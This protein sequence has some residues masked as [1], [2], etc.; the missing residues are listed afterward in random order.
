MTPLP[1]CNQGQ[2]LWSSLEEQQPVGQTPRVY[3]LH[4]LGKTRL[5][6]SWEIRFAGRASFTILLANWTCS[7]SP[8]WGVWAVA[9][10][11]KVQAQEFRWKQFC[12]KQFSG[13]ASDLYFHS[14][15]S[16][17]SFWG[18]G[19]RIHPIEKNWDEKLVGHSHFCSVLNVTP[20]YCCTLSP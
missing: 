12:L 9:L 15:Y 19:Y 17:N 8:S 10:Q 2:C 16:Y 1:A 20:V 6:T 7:I 5:L 4:R 18:C 3:F 13:A 14:V 11:I